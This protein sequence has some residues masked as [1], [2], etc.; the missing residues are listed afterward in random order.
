MAEKKEKSVIYGYSER[1]IFNSIIYYLNSKPELIGKFLEEVLEVN[2]F[3]NNDN[4]SFTFLNE[5]SFSD[6]G[7]NDLTIIIENESETEKTVVFIEG[8]VKTFSGNYSL[9]KEY[10][11]INKAIDKNETF[12]GFS[13]NIF[14]QLYYKYL[15]QDV[16]N[17]ENDE[18][19]NLVDL[20]KKKDR[21]GGKAERRIG[22]NGV[23]LKACNMIKK[24]KCYY[25]I[26]ILPDVTLP[27][28][29]NS[30]SE[31]FEKIDKICMDTE[32][33]KNIK[34]VYWKKIE[35][36]FGNTASVSQNFE[37]NK[38]KDKNG[39]DKSQIYQN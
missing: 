3:I 28:N 31:C 24:A 34:C 20:F 18:T 17:S 22:D 36:F 21:K 8:K 29:I 13:S 15:L 35:E 7:D 33:I 32:N 39:D 14:V 6:F 26:A 16:V 19:T 38:V 4:T 9:D 2:D 10:K 5:Q 25:Y 23:V 27:E 30:F 11:K 37:F 12:D 1:G